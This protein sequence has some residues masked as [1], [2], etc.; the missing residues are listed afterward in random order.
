[1]KTI[2]ANLGEVKGIIYW[3]KPVSHQQLI[4]M[5][6]QQEHNNTSR[7]K[8]IR[9]LWNTYVIKCFT[10]WLSSC[11]IFVCCYIV[12]LAH[13]CCKKNNLRVCFCFK[14]SLRMICSYIWIACWILSENK[15]PLCQCD[16]SYLSSS[17]M[18]LLICFQFL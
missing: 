17:Y 7:K 5:T 6:L 9:I 15:F 8:K 2:S 4:N 1:M 16:L 11:C 14:T 13:W 12:M 18:S 3:I 10:S